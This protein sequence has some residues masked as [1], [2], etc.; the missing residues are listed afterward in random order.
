MLYIISDLMIT[1]DETFEKGLLK[2]RFEA[3]FI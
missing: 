2:R 1:I 3:K